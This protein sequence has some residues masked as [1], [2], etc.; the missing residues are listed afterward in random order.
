MDLKPHQ[1]GTFKYRRNK[2][3]EARVIDIVRLCLHPPEAPVRRIP[4]PQNVE[5]VKKFVHNLFIIFGCEKPLEEKGSDNLNADA[6][7]K[8][9]LVMSVHF[10][11]DRRC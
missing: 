4:I 5:I 2:K 7:Q 8:K 6:V 1:T 11:V 9:K 10:L 3:L